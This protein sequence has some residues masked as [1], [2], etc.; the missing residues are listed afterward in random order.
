MNNST[1]PTT[2]RAPWGVRDAVWGLVF[3]IVAILGLNAVVIAASLV[4]RVPIKLDNEL[5]GVFL[6]AQ[7]SI[8]LMA[9]WLFGMA[10]HQVG[11][12]AL[13]WRGFAPMGCA[14]SAGGLIAA[15]GINIFYAM[16]ALALGMKFSPQDILTRLDLEGNNLIFAFALAA[17]LVPMVEE[18][19]FR[20]FLYGGLRG[21]FGARGA[22]LISAIVFTA[23][24]L[25]LDR[26]IPI[27]VLGL[28]LAWLYERTG[29]IVPGIFLHA[30]NNA[31]ALAAYLV[32][33]NL[34]LPDVPLGIL[35]G[36]LIF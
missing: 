17:G 20:G 9:A 8:F 2:E 18:T 13:G 7:S 4:L 32:V 24:H 28:I 10:R 33:K 12:S 1:L 16:F 34:N 35:F 36:G 25:T 22:M 15:Y 19:F 21:R 5:L 26:F 14:F 31:V 30:T 23:L 29:S 11:W 6:L 27:L 3:V